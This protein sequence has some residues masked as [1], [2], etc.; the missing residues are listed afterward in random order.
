MFR[1]VKIDALCFTRARAYA[2]YDQCFSAASVE[3]GHQK[4]IKYKH[5]GYPERCA[6]ASTA[7][8]VVQCW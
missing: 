3:V 7:M 6:V 8:L 1:I 4:G 2:L 5:V